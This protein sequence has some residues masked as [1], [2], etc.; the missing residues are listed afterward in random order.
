MNVGRKPDARTLERYCVEFVLWWKAKEFVSKYG[1]KFPL[2]DEKGQVKCWQQFPE[3]AE[4]H[5][6]GQTL[7]RIEQ[8]FGLT[9]ASRARLHVEAG[10]SRT[11]SIPVRPR[12]ST[13]N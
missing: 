12:F 10:S 6:R 4:M 7:L 5:K 3:V 9:P 13:N 11:P 1:V 8:E 2:K